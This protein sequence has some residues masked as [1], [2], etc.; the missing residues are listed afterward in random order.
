MAARLRNVN[1]WRARYLVQRMCYGRFAAATVRVMDV[2]TLAF[3]CAGLWLAGRR[4]RERLAETAGALRT[5]VCDLD[6]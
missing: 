3:R 2:V 6:E 5:L 4:E 1:I